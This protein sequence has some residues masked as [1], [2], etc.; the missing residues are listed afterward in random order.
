MQ[1]K[2]YTLYE[3]EQMRGRHR[4]RL[5]PW[6]IGAGIVV[7]ASIVLLFTVRGCGSSVEHTNTGLTVDTV[8]SGDS[9]ASTTTET[10]STTTTTTTLPSPNTTV[11]GY[12]PAEPGDVR[13]PGSFYGPINTTFEGLTTF[14]GNASRTFYG[15]GPVPKNPKILWKFGPMS[16]TS[17]NLGSTTTWTGTGWTGQPCIFEREGK[18]WV[19]FGAYDYKIHFLD[20]ATG[21][22]LLPDFKGKDIFKGSAV[23][24]PDGYPLV[25]M[26]CRDNKWRIIA[27]DRDQPTE[28][29]NLNADTLPNGIWNDDW[30]ASVL[31]RNDYAFEPGENGH[32]YILKLNRS[33]DAEGKVT[34][35]PKIVLDFVGW[36][37]TLLAN[38]GSK[39]VG[40]ENSP[41]LVGERLYFSNSGGLV[42]CLDVS[43]TL[44]DLEEGEAPPEGAAAYPV[45]FQYWTGEDTDATIV[46]DEQG[47]IY[48]CQHSDS[49]RQSSLA[50]Q[51]AKAV[52]QIVKLDPRKAEAGED[53]IVWSQPVTILRSGEAGVW[54]TPTLYK[55]MLYVSTHNG[56]ILGFDRQTG[57]KIWRKDLSYHDWA[58]A[59]VVDQTLVVGDTNG[60]LHAWDVSNTR[61]NPPT[62][63]SFQFPSK[64]ALESSPAVW[65]GRIYIGS[66][67]GYFYCLGD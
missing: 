26:G 4:R 14:R 62:V 52:G 13:M 48:V 38:I 12:N 40:I 35:D 28:L 43:A 44:E 15:E 61:I 10:E 58:S 59:S 23:V 1:P 29:F 37:Q 27:I 47:Y 39:D 17:T 30:D 51:R 20:A 53:P 55:D 5:L 16:G 22:R 21:E 36:T 60:I 8:S 25:Y 65:K 63:W 18:T 6:V 7:I 54:A 41:C 57:E 46:A 33:Y 2:R 9:D 66:R 42:T 19:V 32:F 45:V 56:A 34:V 49:V 3:V 67:D 31:I 64:R 11:A 50:T 24:D